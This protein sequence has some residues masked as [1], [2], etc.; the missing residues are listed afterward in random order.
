MLLDNP[1]LGLRISDLPNQSTEFELIARQFVF[2]RPALTVEVG[3]FCGFMTFNLALLSLH[4]GFPTH[5]H[6]Y[7]IFKHE[8]NPGISEGGLEQITKTPFK[9]YEEVFDCMLKDFPEF[10][11]LITKHKGDSKVLG[12][13]LQEKIDFLIIDGDHSY[14]GIKGD[15]LTFTPKLNDKAIV[16][17]HDYWKDNSRKLGVKKAVDELIMDNPNFSLVDQGNIVIIFKYS[18]VTD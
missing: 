11:K 12:K 17:F 13:E 14:E 1:K 2:K 5:I 15:I 9:S 6:T 3:T 7:D 16:A 18:A 4:W 10:K 8:V